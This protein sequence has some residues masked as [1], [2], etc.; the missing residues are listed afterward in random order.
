LPGTPIAAA[1]RRRA[2]RAATLG[3]VLG[4]LLAASAFVSSGVT[5]AATE[6]D[7]PP[8]PVSN[9]AASPVIEQPSSSELVGGSV[10]FSGTGEPGAGI[11]LFADAGGQP[12]CSVEADSSGAWSCEVALESGPSVTVRA[13]Q[14]VGGEQAETSVVI[15][16]L[17]APTA[18]PGGG[19]TVSSGT[20]MGTGAAGATVT[21]SVGGATCTSTVDA[22][23]GWFCALERG[24][25]SGSYELTASQV[26]PWSNGRSSPS[27]APTTL[28]LDVD[29]P[30]P[31]GVT[32]PASPV[33]ASG[34]AFSGTGENGA[35][36][37]VFAGPNSLCQAVV[38]GGVWSCTAA[39]LDGG[40][41]AVSAIQQDS[42][43]N[44][45]EESARVSVAFGAPAAA[46]PAPTPAPAPATPRPSA[47]PTAGPVQSGA[48]PTAAS[49]L[50]P[51]AQPDATAEAPAEAAPGGWSASTRFSAGMQPA[52]GTAGA[53]DWTL[54]LGIGLAVIALLAVPARLLAG[55]LRGLRP[56]P[57]SPRVGGRLTGRNRSRHEE[58]EVAPSLP[59][60]SRVTSVFALI[61]A[62]TITVLSV[63]VTDEPAYLR[64]LVAVILGILAVNAVAALVPRLI[65]RIVVGVSVEVRLR[66]VFLLVSVGATLLSR[67]LDLDPALVFGLVFGLSLSASA[68]RRL[69]GLLAAL[70]ASSLVVVGATALLVSGS[71]S[72]RTTA[73]ASGTIDAFATEFITTVALSAL[74]GA[75]V[76]LLPLGGLPGRHLLRWKPLLWLLLAV[77]SFTLLAGA[78]SS[79][80]GALGGGAGLILLA[81]CAL[82]FAALCLTVWLWARFVRTPPHDESSTPTA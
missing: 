72:N 55:T 52:F 44:I 50:Q 41:Y 80:L 68:S 47:T 61:A 56:V 22:S 82:G 36:V 48:D 74:G 32:I 59:W 49:P 23:G 39:A 8:T 13:V 38:T 34:A 71:L 12:L 57:E 15:A 35:T 24:L 26:A 69:E 63:P 46:S 53:I 67:A 16:V 75:A 21:A 51:Q 40:V 73:A 11:D 7:P 20:V 4:L 29:A 5:A 17:N 10:P 27:S 79:A 65:A 37:T 33:P 25:A 9:A 58:F 76:L 70:Q 42:A 31:P 6:T 30:T 66:P 62:A 28:T 3:A 78:L 2:A 43:G 81:L 54:A 14:S 64:L 18:G 1:P 19:G 77:V 45:S 60:S